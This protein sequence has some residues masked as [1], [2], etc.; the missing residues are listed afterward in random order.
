M[1]HGI[2][3]DVLNA[4]ANSVT[5]ISASLVFV[6]IRNT[7]KSLRITTFEHLYSRMNYIHNI[8]IEHPKLREYFYDS[9]TV[10]NACQ[11]T[12]EINQAAEMIADF[13]EQISLEFEHMPQDVARGWKAYMHDL[14]RT[15]PALQAHLVNKG[16]WYPTDFMRR[17][18][19][20]FAR[21]LRPD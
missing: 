15:S 5:A 4:I 21:T 11:Y 7:G 13:F 6:Q 3:W 14:V 9:I 1:S 12:A 17:D 2:S 16:G 10:G 20:N 8:F 19:I 18:L